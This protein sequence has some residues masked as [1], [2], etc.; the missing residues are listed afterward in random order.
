MPDNSLL[1]FCRNIQ[2]LRQTHNLSKTKMAKILHISLKTLDHLERGIV[3]PLMSCTVL[4]KAA[5]YFSIPLNTLVTPRDAWDLTN[6]P[7]P[8]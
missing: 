2:Y 3:P 8:D 5:E 4:F 6:P 7:T 1:I